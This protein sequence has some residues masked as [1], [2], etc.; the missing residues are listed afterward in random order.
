MSA[1]SLAQ[2]AVET[3]RQP[4]GTV[5]KSSTEALIA[6][7]PTEALAVYTAL[8]G[9]MLTV[10]DDKNQ[11][12]PFRW[13]AYGT[14]VLLSGL[15]PFI[16]FRCRR[17]RE[18]RHRRFPLRECFTATLAAGAWGAVMPANPLSLSLSAAALTLTTA[19]I[20]LGSAMALALIAQ[21]LGT[22][23]SLNDQQARP[24]GLPTTDPT[25]AAVARVTNISRTSEAKAA[26][27]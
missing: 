14:F 16:M 23:N 5:I 22:A 2:L 25:M 9:V 8:I 4:P 20:T 13:A 18:S 27:S 17:S 26:G 12:R 19:T 11:F 1:N 10:T 3:D 15:I 24:S 6:A 7:I 21:Y